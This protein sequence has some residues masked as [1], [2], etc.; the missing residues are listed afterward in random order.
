MNGPLAGIRVLEA[1]GI[2][3]APFCAMLLADLGAQVLQVTRI[4][5][6][7]SRFDVPG[8][9]RHRIALDLR[10]DEG[11]ATALE[12]AGSADILIEGF[13][14]G[15]MERLGLG[16]SEC[17]QRN[18]RLVY[19]R[20]TGWGQDGPLAQVAGHDIN[21]LG[22]SGALHAIGR[23]GEP[24]V[25]P[26]NLVGDYGGGAMLL[27]VGLLAALQERNVSGRGQ[28]VDAAMSEGSTL[29]A[30]LFYGMRASGRWSGGRGENHLDGGAHFYNAYRC[31]DGRYVAVAANEPQFYA[32]L[33]DLCAIE[34]EMR[35][36]QWDRARWPAFKAQLAQVFLQRSRD[37]WCA[38]A[39]GRDACL[40]PVLDWDE[41][42][43]H[44]QHRARGGFVTVDG[45]V[46]PAP[47]PRFSRTPAG[48]PQA[49]READEDFLRAWRR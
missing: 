37:E 42:P 10:S 1:G 36:A 16:P 30:S 13:R 17:M 38:L 31:A 3:P 39:E 18:P 45:V 19:G 2:G 12:L 23:P 21:Y 41:A 22:L 11:R 26:L 27:A 25:P 49:S 20:M 43:A 48:Q 35:T 28:V 4:G 33:M 6:E 40:T 32:Q 46:Q 14:P 34:G 44:P 47:A 5:A 9:G 7:A 15:V 24:P 29:L 8:R